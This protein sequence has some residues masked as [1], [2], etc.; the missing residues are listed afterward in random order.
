L[1]PF[2]S[3]SFCLPVSSPKTLRLKIYKTITLPVVLYGCETW[4]LTLKEKHGLRMF[5]WGVMRIFETKREE[6]TGGWRRQRI[7]ELF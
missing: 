2:G 3:E 7:E 6:V 1:P 4:S 5:E